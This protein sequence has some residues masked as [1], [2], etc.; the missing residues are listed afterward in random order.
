M[1]QCTRLHDVTPQ[2]AKCHQSPF[3]VPRKISCQ[4]AGPQNLTPRCAPGQLEEDNK[5]GRVG[6]VF[7]QVSLTLLVRIAT[8]PTVHLR[9]QVAQEAFTQA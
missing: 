9:L 4:G 3:T 8:A 1:I 2:S 7:Y 6:Q 5:S